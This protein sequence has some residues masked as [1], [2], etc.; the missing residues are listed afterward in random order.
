MLEHAHMNRMQ[1]KH[2][3]W[4][5][6]RSDT[7]VILGVPGSHEGFKTPV[8]P[9]NSFSPGVGSYGVST[10]IFADG[11]L[12]A[13][14]LMPLS[15][16]EWS[17]ADSRV[18]VLRSRWRAG[19]VDVESRL[20]ADGDAETNDIKNYLAVSIRNPTSEPVRLTF[21]L[22]LRSF[23]AA[24]GPVRSLSFKDDRVLVNG[25]PVLYPV[26]SPNGFG[27]VSY[28]E[29]ETDISALLMRNELPL[30]DSVSDEST[31]ASGA[32][33]YDL[34][35]QPD[36]TRHLD[37]ICHVHA[38]YSKLKWL[39]PPPK[40]ASVAP[41][42]DRFTRSWLDQTTIELDVPDY[43]FRDAFF[44]QLTHL[45]MFTVYDEP[46]ITP[47][48][49]PM[50]WLRDGAYVVT[51]LDKGGYHDFAERA[52]RFV[53][54]RDAFGGFG[55][56]GDGPSEGI[57]ILSEHYLLTGSLDFL[58]D[59]YPDIERKANLLI[60]MLHTDVPITRKTEF[61]TSQMLLSP[62]SDLMCLPADDGMIMG[63]MD[64]HFPI[65]WINAFAWF[66][67]TRA[68]MC[69]E[70]LGEDG[71]W[72]AREADQLRRTLTRRA[73]ELFGKN[74][75]DPNSA[76]WPTGWASREDEVIKRG[77]DQ[78]WDTVRC[79]NGQYAREPMWTYFEAGQAHNYL[80]LGRPDRAWMTIEHF[81]TEH[82]APGLYTYSEGNGDENSSLQWQR[83]RGW[84]RIRYV[85]PHGWTA[86]EVFLLLRDCLVREE[87][88]ALIVGSGI[89][90]SWLT[91][92]FSVR[93]LPTYFGAVSVHYSPEK[94]TLDVEVERLPPGGVH[95]NLPAECSVTLTG[96]TVT[97]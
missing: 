31:W 3:D 8:E 72:F 19:T 94:G 33:A 49:Y 86:A 7:H 28:A 71:N 44:S 78:F 60:Q 55:A 76:F 52:V 30:T 83:T 6:N 92:P 91:E 95:T 75:R 9:G 80:L 18:P 22:A 87:D 5:W 93:N 67:L 10:W 82:I 21:Y 96:S 4:I 20:F 68:A 42:E 46:R 23:G 45:R 26:T 62:D 64:G 85:T 57:W 29:A 36:E 48:S 14:E 16:L 41:Q 53:A 74:D 43:R 11:R 54:S 1:A 50:W 32:L 63:R 40:G 35:L 24:G 34:T 17:F 97:S 59:I 84:D 37:F 15:E 70:A 2:P 88:N 25:A 77:F 58:R 73:P 47:V 13:P 90:S 56:E 65:L 61:R 51:A 81:L 89:P 38:N 12:H 69:A 66:G 39:K 79:P 27:A